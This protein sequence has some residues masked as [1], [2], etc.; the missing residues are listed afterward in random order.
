MRVG[1]K[2]RSRAVEMGGQR[3]GRLVVLARDGCDASG[4]ARWL[5]ECDCGTT[6]LIAGTSLRHGGTVSCGCYSR[7]SVSKRMRIHGATSTAEYTTWKEMRSRCRYRGHRAWSLYG[8]RGIKVCE[9]WRRSFANFLADMGL[10]PPGMSI[11]R[12]D[13]NGNYEPGNCRWATKLEQAHNRRG[14]VLTPISAILL[15]QIWI[16]S[17]GRRVHVARAFGVRL[18]TAHDVAASRSWRSAIA[19]LA[20]T[21]G[22]A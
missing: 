14:N 2:G 15:R 17:F 13:S 16:R 7:E 12:I 3:F 5:C 8:G 4:S 11:D 21:E 18:T 22:P 10:R 20:T 6:K 1:S 19:E 9:R